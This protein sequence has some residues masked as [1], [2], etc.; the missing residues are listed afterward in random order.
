M[1]HLIDILDLSPAEID[2]LIATANDI[3]DH[4][5][6]YA[7][8]CHGK[9]LRVLPGF[10]WLIRMAESRVGVA[11][12]VFGTLTYDMSMSRAF[13]DAGQLSFEETIRRTEDE[14]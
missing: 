2:Q 4:P 5:A 9:K 11:G 13:A 3:I 12:K 14:R 6:D 10:G 7:E 1:R 8:K